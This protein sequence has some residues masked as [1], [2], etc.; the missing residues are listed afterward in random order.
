MAMKIKDVE[1]MLKFDWTQSETC[2]NDFLHKKHF[3]R[4]NYV[5]F[6]ILFVPL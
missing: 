3:G 6:Q 1:K 2:P 4:Q 5:I